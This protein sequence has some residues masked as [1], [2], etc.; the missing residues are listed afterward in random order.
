MAD[1]G[2]GVHGCSSMPNCSESTKGFEVGFA[3]LL[4]GYPDRNYNLD[5]PTQKEHD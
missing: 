2:V 1:S 5:K 3:V 4:C